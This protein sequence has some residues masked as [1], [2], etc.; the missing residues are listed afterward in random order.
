ME[1]IFPLLT[2]VLYDLIIIGLLYIIKYA[3]ECLHRKKEPVL[4]F[5]VDLFTFEEALQYVHTCLKE[6][7]GMQIVTINPE[8][9]SLGNKDKEFAAVL[10]NADLVI[11]DGVGVKIALKIKGI[12]QE[13]IPGIEF[14]KKLIG[15][16]ELEGFSIGL[17]GAKEEVIQKAVQNIRNEHENLNI[18]YIRNGYF[19]EEQEKIII[20]ELKAVSPRVLFVALGA[21]KQELFISKLKP[22]MPNT[23]FIGVG[24]SFDVW[25]GMVKRAPKIYQ[26]LGLEWLYRTVK[27]PA[28]FKRIFPA[29]PMFLI[30]VII[31]AIHENLVK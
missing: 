9:I 7:N 30:Q 2:I 13:N 5:G 15:M 4:G 21:P 27:E 18:T 25:S 22:Q 11:P 12:S 28:R 26:T 16:C 10:N 31:E 8:M 17:I 1:A 23:V 6:N 24:G 14:S 19:D 3:M 20:E 29:L